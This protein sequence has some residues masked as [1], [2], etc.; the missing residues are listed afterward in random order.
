M[1]QV[2]NISIHAY[3]EKRGN[4]LLLLDVKGDMNMSNKP[5]SLRQRRL[6]DEQTLHAVNAVKMVSILALRNEGWG[7]KRL[8]KFSDSFNVIVEDVS[9]GLL[10]LSDIPEA[11]QKET[12]LGLEEL[13]V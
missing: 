6:Q 2:K 4:G 9:Q 11:I 10:S 12:G 3:I 5:L 1:Q 8:K 13:R 7:E